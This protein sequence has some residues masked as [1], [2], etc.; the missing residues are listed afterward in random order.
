MY[1]SSKSQNFTE[2]QVRVPHH[3]SICKISRLCGVIAPLLTNFKALFPAVSI[4]ILSLVLEGLPWVPEVF[5]R[6]RRGASFCRPQAD[7]R[8]RLKAED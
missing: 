5:C 8:V 7:T 1:S 6:V 2:G 3:T 4:D